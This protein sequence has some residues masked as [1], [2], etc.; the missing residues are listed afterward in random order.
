[1]KESIKLLA[2]QGSYRLFMKRR[3]DKAFLGFSQKVFAR[4]HHQCQFCGFT[5]VEHMEVINRDSNYTHNK[6][7]NLITACPFCAQ[8]FFLDAVG[9]GDF[10]GGTLIFLPELS[11]EDL[12]ALCHVLFTTIACGHEMSSDAKDHYRSLKARSKIVESK[13][14]E[15]LSKPAMYGQMLLDAIQDVSGLHTQVC[16]SVRLLP[17]LKQFAPMALVWAESAISQIAS[18]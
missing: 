12:N 3:A 5:A 16:A 8:C 7:S 6:M 10:G 15:G 17:N 2:I 9:Q 14:G 4:D 11:Q 1:M 18:V 13:L